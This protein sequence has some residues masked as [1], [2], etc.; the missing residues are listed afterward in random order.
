MVLT[1]RT[2]P[3]ILPLI[4]KEETSPKVPDSHPC[5]REMDAREGKRSASTR[6]RTKTEND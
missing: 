6:K 1:G 4:T 3:G 5:P 2:N